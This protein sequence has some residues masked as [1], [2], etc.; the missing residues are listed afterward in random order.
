VAPLFLAGAGATEQVAAAVGARLL[1]GDPVGAAAEL[2]GA[3]SRALAA[4]A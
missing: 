1:R 3:P 4:P 2:A